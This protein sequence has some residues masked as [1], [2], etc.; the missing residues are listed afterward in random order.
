VL[1][2]DTVFNRETLG[3]AGRLFAPDAASVSRL[4]DETDASPGY[5]DALRTRAQARVAEYYRWD[6]I[7]DQYE[8]LFLSSAASG[9]G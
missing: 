1:A 5:A 8:A 3:D 7:V 9:R 2:R 6:S 4:I